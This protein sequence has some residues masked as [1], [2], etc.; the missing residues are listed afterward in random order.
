MFLL[1]KQHDCTKGTL[2]STTP[3]PGSYVIDLSHTHAGFA[4][5]HFGLS[6]VRGEFTQVEGTV[7]IADDPTSSWVTATI[8]TPS[9]ESR[10]AKRDEHVRSSDFLDVEQFPD[11]TFRSTNVKPDG[12][13]WV[14]SGDLTIK[15]VTRTVDLLTEFEGSITDPYG[16]QRIAFSASTEIDRTD[17]GLDFNA[18]VETGGLVVGKNIKIVLEV[19]AIVPRG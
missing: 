12:D 10:D 5:K 11:I 3:P 17:F 4:V 18:V 19:Q 9:F 13:D 1:A 15:G 2:M 16:L 7:V 6:K 8:A 14:V